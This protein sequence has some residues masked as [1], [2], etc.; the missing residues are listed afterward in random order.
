MILRQA[1]VILSQDEPAPHR[2]RAPK[3][4]RARKSLKP[5]PNRVAE[6]RCGTCSKTKPASEFN[7]N[8]ARPNGLQTQCK[9]CQRASQAAS[10]ERRAAKRAPKPTKGK[11]PD[12][13]RRATLENQA[14]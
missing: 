5:P 14:R 11:E 3:V 2:A 9:L 6:A 10:R 7:V 1:R 8:R 13:M 4:A 12:P